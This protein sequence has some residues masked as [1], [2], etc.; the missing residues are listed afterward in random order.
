MSD[1]TTKQ[2]EPLAIAGSSLPYSE[3]SKKSKY[4]SYRLMNFTIR[5]SLDL[6]KVTWRS[7]HTWRQTDAQFAVMDGEGLTERRKQLAAE[8]LN[9]EF[10]RNFRMVLEKDFRV[11]FKTLTSP[12]AMTKNDQEYLLKL[13]SHYTPQHLGIIKQLLDGG[14]V[15]KPFDFTK[16]TMTLR[17]E[18][19]Q[20]LEIRSG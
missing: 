15:D 10:N 5:E 3:D 4:L 6:A 12:E 1:I 17:T 20:Q 13:R 16:L 9:I 11:L 7:L 18:R 14:D 19:V 2:P 8:Y